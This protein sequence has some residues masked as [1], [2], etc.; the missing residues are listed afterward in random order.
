[1]FKSLEAMT[2]G[3]SRV[4]NCGVDL[5]VKMVFRANSR[6]TH[7][8]TFMNIHWQNTV[9]PTD[10]FLPWSTFTRLVERHGSDRYV[11][12]LTCAEQFRVMAAAHDLSRESPRYRGLPLGAI[13][14]SCCLRRACPSLNFRAQATT[15]RQT[16]SRPPPR[17]PPALRS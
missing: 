9:C 16:R 11:K 3:T 14:H 12:S 13:C 10:G 7:P 17:K 4:E 6:V 1:M 15:T 2:D 5:N 8:G